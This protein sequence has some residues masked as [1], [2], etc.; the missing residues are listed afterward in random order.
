[1]RGLSVGRGTIPG[2]TAMGAGTGKDGDREFRAD[3]SRELVD[4]SSGF[5]RLASSRE[6]VSTFR[7]YPELDIRGWCL[8]DLGAKAGSVDLLYVAR[9]KPG[10]EISAGIA[11]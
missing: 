8:I 2:S 1:M 4:I 5:G 10:I 11:L 6:V 3:T 9:V 7:L